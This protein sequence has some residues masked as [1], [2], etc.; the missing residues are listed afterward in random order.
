VVVK[1]RLV[2]PADD[3]KLAFPGLGFRN[4]FGLRT[5]GEK[6]LLVDPTYLADVY[7]AG[8]ELAT[9]LRAKGLFLMDF[10]GD[11]AAPVWWK[12]PFLV[13]PASTHLAESDRVPEQGVK[14][15]VEEIGCDSGSF[16]FL[17]LPAELPRKIRAKVRELLDEN[18]AVALRLPAGKWTAYYEQ[19]KAPQKNM[20]GLYRN[21][22]LKHTPT[23]AH[24]A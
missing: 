20:M 9:Y 22:V 14:V 21:I 5:A 18:N 17:P 16:V 4:S 2:R 8:D 24:R 19:F 10:G 23:V 1:T 13:I 15:L 11:I 3:F 12:P 7:N 6:I